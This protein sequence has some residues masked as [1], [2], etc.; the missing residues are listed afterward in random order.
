MLDPLSG[1]ARA[2]GRV[3]TMLVEADH[4]GMRAIADLVESEGLR[5]RVD[6]TFR[7]EQAA[8]AHGLRGDEPDHGQDRAGGVG[9][10]RGSTGSA[11]AFARMTWWENLLGRGGSRW[12]PRP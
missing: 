1:L 8:Q 5:A 2:G 10:G 4:T 11:G 9:R 12:R 7:L 3:E 6:M